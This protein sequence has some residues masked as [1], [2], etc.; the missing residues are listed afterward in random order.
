MREKQSLI[1]STQSSLQ[2]STALLAEERARLDT[3]RQ[4][5][6]RRSLLR[7][8]IANLRAANEQCRAQLFA[9]HP[10]GATATISTD[11]KIGE[12]DAGLEVDKTVLSPKIPKTTPVNLTAQQRSYVT[13]LPTTAVLKARVE[14]YRKINAR[15]EDE[16][17][18]LR[19]QSSEL[20]VK[21]RKV[22]ALSTAT[23]EE[24]VDQLVASLVT[25]VESEGREGAEVGRLRNFLRRVE[26]GVDV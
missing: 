9:Q 19:N 23:G 7:Q 5:Q 1:D 14:A 26:A 6:E 16:G 18:K 24:R 21:L 25:A 13:A 22:V 2:Q 17:S 15:L 3:L 8:R 10:S 12:A 4:K 11:T 20:E